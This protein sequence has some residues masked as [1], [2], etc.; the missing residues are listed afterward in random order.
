MLF[1]TDSQNL[2]MCKIQGLLWV[3]GHTGFF[4]V[5]TTRHTATTRP[6]NRSETETE[7]ARA[8]RQRQE[9]TEQEDRERE[10]KTEEERQERREKMQEKLKIFLLNSVKYDFLCFFSV[11]LGR[12]TFF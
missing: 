5:Y 3:S 9:E 2:N 10:E 1:S 11:P 4:S 8:R 6:Q 12:S 7:W